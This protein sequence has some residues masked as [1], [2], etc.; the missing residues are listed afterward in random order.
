V[1]LRLILPSGRLD[2]C[3]HPEAEPAEVS[4]RPIRVLPNLLFPSRAGGEGKECTAPPP[5]CDEK[6]EDRSW[7]RGTGPV[8]AGEGRRRAGREG[9]GRAGTPTP[10]A[11]PLN[12]PRLHRRPDVSTLRPTSPSLPLW[13]S[14]CSTDDVEARAGNLILP[15]CWP[16]SRR[17]AAPRW[18]GAPGLF[19]LLSSPSPCDVPL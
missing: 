14:L 4:H 10:S 19:M 17:T 2:R 9:Q 6:T 1:A 3:L 11:T 13:I 15:V 8:A 5:R 18:A 7:L 16:S 12:R